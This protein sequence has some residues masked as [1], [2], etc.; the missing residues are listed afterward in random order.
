MYDAQ[1]VRIEKPESKRTTT[2]V[3]VISFSPPQN[4]IGQR[5]NQIRRNQIKR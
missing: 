3:A 1:Y 2:I 4:D 5:Q